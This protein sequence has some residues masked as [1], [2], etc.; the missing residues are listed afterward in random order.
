MGQLNSEL[1]GDILYDNNVEYFSPQEDPEPYKLEKSINSYK[2]LLIYAINNNG[3]RF[4]ALVS[5][6]KG[7]GVPGTSTNTIFPLTL[8]LP[9]STGTAAAIWLQSS[10]FEKSEDGTELRYGA[11]CQLRVG[12]S[13]SSERKH[14]LGIT[15]VI[16]LM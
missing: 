16:G 15:K 8:I 2:K 13:V 12:Q 14:Y 1:C 5:P 10:A 11:G 9:I 7:S 4:F 6:N 3:V